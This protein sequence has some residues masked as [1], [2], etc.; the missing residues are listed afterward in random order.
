M[1]VLDTAFRNSVGRYFSVGDF[2]VVRHSSNPSRLLP[3]VIATVESAVFG[4]EVR[5]EAV[6][7]AAIMLVGSGESFN[8]QVDPEAVFPCFETATAEVPV[9]KALKRY[10]NANPILVA[11]IR[12]NAFLDVE[13][14]QTLDFWQGRLDDFV[15]ANDL[16][17]EARSL[18]DALREDVARARLNALRRESESKR[19]T[20]DEAGRR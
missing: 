13:R 12:S 9:P 7:S 3:C 15:D 19:P 14:F 11:I 4:D 17:D 8:A 18:V 2:A 1:S 20:I 5:R 16:G 6:V 10:A